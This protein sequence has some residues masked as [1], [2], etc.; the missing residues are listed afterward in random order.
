MSKMNPK[1]INNLEKLLQNNDLTN[2]QTKEF[3][4]FSRKSKGRIY[5]KVIKRTA[6]Y[7]ILYAIFMSVYITC[8]NNTVLIMTAKVITAAVA[9]LLIGA[10]GY[11]VADKYLFEKNVNE[12]KEIRQIE[13]INPEVEEKKPIEEVKETVLKKETAAEKNTVEETFNPPTIAL[14]R[15]A[16]KTVDRKDVNSINNLFIKRLSDSNRKYVSFV[17]REKAS[18]SPY[19][20]HGSIEKLGESFFFSVKVIDTKTTKVVFSSSKEYDSIES[21]K[22]NTNELA[23][24]VKTKIQ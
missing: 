20:I 19:A 21:I 8:K 17:S 4:K 10:G 18:M 11:F 3:K 13:E 9:A 12:I 7:S 14:V 23:N 15:F 22:N 6:Q 24:K 1:N 2:H 16:S 5:K